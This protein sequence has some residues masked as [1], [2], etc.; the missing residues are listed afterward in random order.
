M[1]HSYPGSRLKTRSF[2]RQKLLLLLLFALRTG[3]D[4]NGTSTSEHAVISN[5]NTQLATQLHRL[6]GG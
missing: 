1:V 6:Q 5:T 3:L 2:M 4:V